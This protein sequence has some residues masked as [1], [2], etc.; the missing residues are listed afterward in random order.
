[1]LEKIAIKNRL[2]KVF[3]TGAISGIGESLGRQYAKKGTT[4]NLNL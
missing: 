2:L 4:L 3:I 1:M